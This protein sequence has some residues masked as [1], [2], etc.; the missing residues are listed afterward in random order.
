MF[1]GVTNINLD[2]K[3][4]LA[5]PTR[6]RDGL[7]DCC[8]S[9]LVITADTDRSLLIYPL[10]EWHQIERKLMRLPTFNKTARQLQRLMVGYATEVEM[11]AQGRVLLPAPL[12][13]FARLDKHVVLVGQGT[14]FELW[15]AERWNEQQGWID[16]VD[17]ESL[18]LPAG[19]EDL[20]I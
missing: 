6:Y 17:L 19:L 5:I 3:G 10:P 8:G 9:E 13:E 15:D 14:K 7:R 4:R 11:D 16:G 12:R 2:A 1:R 18:D 20:S